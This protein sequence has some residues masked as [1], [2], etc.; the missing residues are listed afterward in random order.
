MRPGSTIRRSRWFKRLQRA[1]RG[2][3][4]GAGA[5]RPASPRGVRILQRKTPNRE[6][7]GAEGWWPGT[8]SNRRHE[9]FQSSALPTELPGRKGCAATLDARV[10]AVPSR[11][12]QEI[13]RLTADPVHWPTGRNDTKQIIQGNEQIVQGND[14]QK[15]VQRWRITPFY[16]LCVKPVCQKNVRT[17]GKAM[18]KRRNPQTGVWGASLWPYFW[19]RERESNSHS[20]AGTG[21]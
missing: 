13:V 1:G 18:C 8:E 20:L 17:C 14:R 4:S 6:R 21:F 3:Q 5:L 12:D 19:C 2:L 16:G 9:D 10:V 15:R 7:L 11:S